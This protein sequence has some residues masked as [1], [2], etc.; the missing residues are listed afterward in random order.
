MWIGPV[1]IVAPTDP[2]KIE[3]VVKHD[4]LRNEGYRVRKSMERFFRNGLLKSDGE[5]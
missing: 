3:N 1:L 5:D 4:K 2:D